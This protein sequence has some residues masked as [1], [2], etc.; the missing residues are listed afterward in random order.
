MATPPSPQ[1]ESKYEVLSG[2]GFSENLSRNT[3]IRKRNRQS[4]ED[5]LDEAIW[6]F[7]DDGRPKTRRVNPQRLAIRLGPDLVA[8]MEALI[9]PG[10]KMPTFAIRKDFQERYQ[11]DRRHI[12]DYFHSRGLRVAK[13]DKHTNLIRGRAL[14][15]Q[16]QL[17]T[18]HTVQTSAT[19]VLPDFSLCDVSKSVSSLSTETLLSTKPRGRA[20]RKQTRPQDRKRRGIRCSSISSS[21]VK[22]VMPL[23]SVEPDAG[24]VTSLSGTDTE[25]ESTAPCPQFSMPCD[26]SDDN[27]ESSTIS[28]FLPSPDDFI[29]GYFGSPVQFQQPFQESS[30][31]GLDS[32]T[33]MDEHRLLTAE[34]RSELYDLINNNISKAF[35]EAAGTY[36]SY[37]SEK[38]RS[39]LD[40][41]NPLSRASRPPK[42]MSTITRMTT[43]DSPLSLDSLDLRKWFA[44]EFDPSQPAMSV[45]DYHPVCDA[46]DDV[47]LTNGANIGMSCPE[48]LPSLPL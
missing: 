47:S 4:L 17:Q 28:D 19:T 31:T 39:R 22:I 33:I 45:H 5:N 34:E 40:R 23:A 8:E 16:A 41:V 26:T 29:T 9:V 13:E 32:F 46:L 30:V 27:A 38:S 35:E 48:G 2:M 20:A 42:L 25:W 7:P 6:D 21:K 11:V 36:N 37:I 24:I 18:T 15:A 10:A 12:Y 1:E 44:D 14:K 43:I 3:S